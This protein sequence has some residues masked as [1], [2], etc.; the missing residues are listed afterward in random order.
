ML[1]LVPL[2]VLQPPA[3]ADRFA[4]WEKEV[5]AVEARLKKDPP[6]PGGV[7]FAGSSSIRLW[8]LKASFPKLDAV[9]VG[10]G[11]SEV[12]D[13]THFAARLVAPHKPRAVVFYAGDNDLNSGR[14]P[15]RVAADFKAF[16]AAVRAD[17]PGRRVLFVAVKPSPARA[18]QRGRQD[19]ANALVRKHCAAGAGLRFVDVVPLMLG[20]DGK[21]VPELYAKDG[22]HLS[23]AGYAKWAAAVRDALAD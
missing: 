18:A 13:C 10:F 17:D 21:P 5:A 7:V 8:D 1:A 12:R 16:V 2:V 22:L 14:T 9:N 19:E 4:G 20:P 23:P 15:A 3:A 11:G 6:K